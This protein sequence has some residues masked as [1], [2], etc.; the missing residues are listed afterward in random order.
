MNECRKECIVRSTISDR[1]ALGIFVHEN[2][3][4]NSPLRRFCMEKTH[5]NAEAPAAFIVHFV[6]GG[7][8][9]NF[10]EKSN[11]IAGKRARAMSFAS[12][13]TPVD[14][15]SDP[16]RVTL[17]LVLIRLCL[18]RFIH[19]FTNWRKILLMSSMVDGGF[20]RSSYCRM[21]PHKI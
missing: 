12:M 18:E 20:S 7:R 14:S 16:K 6:C 10:E 21:Q 9:T 8:A 3:L 2:Q 19:L 4:E 11:I 15:I 5:T 17:R 13:Y 1:P